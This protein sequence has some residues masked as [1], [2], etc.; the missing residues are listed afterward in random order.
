M[1][2]YV[3]VSW[4]TFRIFISIHGHS[5]VLVVYIPHS[6]Y[7]APPGGL[8]ISSPLEHS[9]WK[10]A[11]T[12]AC[13]ISC[14]F[15]SSQQNLLFKIKF[16]SLIFPWTCSICCSLKECKSWPF[17]SFLTK[18]IDVKS[19]TSTLQEYR[20]RLWLLFDMVG[21]FMNFLASLK[22][23]WTFWHHS[24]LNLVTDIY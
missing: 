23:V 5:L 18:R 13:W 2:T 1:L 10:S 20:A 6:I 4:F 12:F 15:P 22:A 24:K 17:M 8:L 21:T 11:S 16:F 9:V 3:S 14:I 19:K 7:L